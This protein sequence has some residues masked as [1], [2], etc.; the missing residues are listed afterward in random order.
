MPDEAA[1]RPIEHC[2]W[3]H[4][5]R[6]SVCRCPDCGR[7]FCREC[8]TE[9]ESRL[10]CAA[11]LRKETQTVAGSRGGVRRFIAGG[12]AVAGV[13][14][15]WAIFFGAAEGLVTITERSERASWQNR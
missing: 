12:M 4:G 14:L 6:E 15:A 7:C 1:S 10:L 11:C 3:N 5:A 13:I 8:V 9:H 2:C